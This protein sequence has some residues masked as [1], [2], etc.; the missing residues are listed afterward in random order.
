MRLL[1]TPKEGI[2][3]QQA[4]PEVRDQASTSARF[5]TVQNGPLFLEMLRRDSGLQNYQ[6]I[7]VSFSSIYK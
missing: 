2:L 7:L 3:S 5:Y 4:L 1:A 6:F